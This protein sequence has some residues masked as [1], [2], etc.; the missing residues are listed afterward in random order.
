[1]KLSWIKIHN[2][3]YGG[4][5]YYQRVRDFLKKKLDFKEI[6]I[7]PEKMY[8]RYLKP[9]VWFFQIL[10]IKEKSDIW[11]RDSFMTVALSV[12]NKQKGKNIAL[13]HH[14]DGSVFPLFIR[15]IFFIIEKIFYLELKKADVV[16]AVSEYW[17]NCFLKKGCKKVVK[18]YNSLD[19][20]SFEFSQEEIYQ[21]RKKY[22][23][24]DKP[25]VYIGNCQRPKG[26]VEA[27]NVLKDLDVQ[28]VTSGEE[29]VKIPAKNL[30]LE[31]REYLCLLRS[32]SV[33]VTMSKFK[34]GWC[35]T[36][37]E[38]MLCKT[39]VI[40][41]GLGG[42][43][44][45]L[46]GG[47]QIVCGDFNKL[48]ERVEFLLKNNELREKMGLDGF[49]YAKNFTTERFEREWGELINTFRT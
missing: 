20:N 2:K 16:V 35:L 9:L 38:A 42:M 19:I 22:G 29:Q 27:Y 10:N 3:K 7:G 21:F 6:V 5:I 46:Q 37:H 33:V 25:I 24:L 15:P 26:V 12:F 30:N 14:I 31:Y 40:G 49:N 44:E 34:E 11:V 32:A 36:A 43:K 8:I 4:S 48:K 23:I 41:S 1:M 47:K 45:L 28:L 18:I 39:P 13:I 17:K